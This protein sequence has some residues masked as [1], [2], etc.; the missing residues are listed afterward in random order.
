MRV[1]IRE[2]QFN[3]ILLNEFGPGNAYSSDDYNGK[4]ARQFDNRFNTHISRE[5]AFPL[6]YTSEQVWRSI[7]GCQLATLPGFEDD[8]MIFKDKKECETVNKILEAFTE[9]YFPFSGLE[10]LDRQTKIHI[11]MGMASEFNADDIISFSINNIGGM[12][13]PIR[14]KVHALE[15]KLDYE[16]HWVL[17]VKTYNKIIKALGL[18]GKELSDDP[19]PDFLS[20]YCGAYSYKGILTWFDCYESAVERW[21]EAVPLL[22]LK[23]LIEN[24]GFDTTIK[25][26]FKSSSISTG[27]QAEIIT[28]LT[29]CYIKCNKKVVTDGVNEI[30]RIVPDVIKE[31]TIGD[32]TGINA[33]KSLYYKVVNK[34]EDSFDE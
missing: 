17:S 16:L 11:L 9:N 21:G 26:I 28:D 1:I 3:R 4:P 8:D 31:L 33:V 14:D 2:N 24:K 20:Q 32:I 25:E 18:E 30:K 34:I 10:E 13:S 27:I 6:N 7:K 19:H 23:E 5:W 22:Q 29:K 12:S 15:D